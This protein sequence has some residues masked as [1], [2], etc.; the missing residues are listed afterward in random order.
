MA[1]FD[2]TDSQDQDPDPEPEPWSAEVLSG[3]HHIGTET[4][5]DWPPPLGECIEGDFELVDLPTDP[6]TGEV[7]S[8]VSLS[9]HHAGERDG[10][11]EING[12]A[13]FS[14]V[15]WVDIVATAIA[16]VLVDITVCTITSAFPGDPDCDP[17]AV[18]VETTSVS[19]GVS[20][21]LLNFGTN[22]YR[23]CAPGGDFLIA[24]GIQLRESSSS[25]E[26][27][28]TDSGT[29]TGMDTDVAPDTDTGTDTDTDS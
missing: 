16:D 6:D 19:R 29:D 2:R 14:R 12:T 22:S 13:V 26:S 8:T 24:S 9:F 1:I 11:I 27:P 23:V 17:I 4:I 20:T 28:D 3:T 21:E 10:L 25:D 18:D 7:D 15:T 5:A